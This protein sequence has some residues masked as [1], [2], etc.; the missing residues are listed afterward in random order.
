M[1]ITQ[2]PQDVRDK[3]AELDLELS[4]GKMW[5]CGGVVWCC[6]CVWWCGCQNV[7]SGGG[8]GGV[9]L[10]WCGCVLEGN[11]VV[12]VWFV[13][14]LKGNDRKGRFIVVWC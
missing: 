5:W 1:D 6:V 2:L 4:E 3:L 12:V 14:V 11:S 10:L 8:G 9:V 7:R 13:V